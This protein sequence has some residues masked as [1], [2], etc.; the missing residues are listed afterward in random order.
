M[1]V[2]NVGTE[3]LNK[4]IRD[5]VKTRSST[6]KEI[7]VGDSFYRVGDK[8]MQNKNNLEKNVF[9]GELGV[10]KNIRKNKVENSEE[11]ICDFNGTRVIYERSELAEI[12]L[13]YA[14]TIHKSQ[15]GEAPIVI[16]PITL[17]HRVMLARNLYYTGITRAKEKVV[18]I[19]D[20][21]AM[22]VAIQNNQVTLR[23][24][25]LDKRIL[26]YQRYLT[27]KKSDNRSLKNKIKT[28]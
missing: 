20:E 9:N 28:S 25:L 18:L 24:S 13:G 17:E 8:I 21:N 19:G 27:E 26:E 3:I 10:I 14:I 12:E 23:N 4:M 2:R 22:N 11:I 6:K 15:G 7:K 1:K 5:V 16:M